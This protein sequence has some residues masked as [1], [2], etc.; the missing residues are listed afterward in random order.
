M[1]NEAKLFVHILHFH[2]VLHSSLDLL[3]NRKSTV[4]NELSRA[5]IIFERKAN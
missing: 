1:S 3:T 4:L 5:L 2:I